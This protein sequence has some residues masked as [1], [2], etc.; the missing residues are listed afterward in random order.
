MTKVLNWIK[1]NVF[2]VVFG[3]VM[4][5]A[6]VAGPLVS[7]RLNDSVLAEASSRAGKSTNLTSLEKTQ[8][9]LPVPG[10]ATIEHTSVINPALI[11]EYRKAVERL[12][13]DSKLIREMAV[14]FN[15]K[16]RSVL[17][18]S[19]FPKPPADQRET[20]PFEFV[21]RVHDAYAA[22]LR[23]VG[24]GM[25]PTESELAEDLGRREAQYISTIVK[26]Q[27]R[28]QLD[29]EELKGLTEELVKTR[30]A[31]C[32]EVAQ[33]LGVYLLPNALDLPEIPQGR[34]P[35]MSEMYNWQW[36]FWIVD[37]ILHA[38]EDSRGTS[39]SVL[40]APVKRVVSIHV[41][42]HVSPGVPSSNSRGDA[43]GS[44]GSGFSLGGAPPPQPQEQEQA[45]VGGS[46]VDPTVEAPLDYSVSFTGRKSNSLYDVRNVEL[47]VIVAADGLSSLIDAL[48]KRNFITTIDLSVAPIDAYAAASNGYVYREPVIQATLRLETIWLREWTSRRMP[49]DL[50]RQLGIAEE[51]PSPVT[52]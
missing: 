7:S 6:L 34:L 35:T 48:A 20:I 49:E 12:S 5:A 42:D 8:L 4:V 32:D 41:L 45:A 52:Q 30:R 16:N 25:P 31:R 10:G 3:A 51:T 19:L 44:G 36:T 33:H 38:I 18:D 22:L 40:D 14:N 46:K 17:L 1:A 27:N 47:V 29:A 28:S 37:D 23:D 13:S 21:K 2:I 9:Q 26:K 24:A 39:D 11:E 15:S 43:P 50:K